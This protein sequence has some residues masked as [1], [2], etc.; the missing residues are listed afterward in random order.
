MPPRTIT[1]VMAEVIAQGHERQFGGAVVGQESHP[2]VGAASAQVGRDTI[3][4][5]DEETQARQVTPRPGAQDARH[6]GGH[7][8][9]DRRVGVPLPRVSHPRPDAERVPGGIERQRR[10][11]VA[12]QP[13]DVIGAESKQVGERAG[14]G[15]PRGE[16]AAHGPGPSAGARG[17]DDEVSRP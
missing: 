3:A 8:V 5:R 13:G 2:Q 15:Q 7:G 6:Q 11:R 16:L 4:G 12:G 14:A 1:N 10:G 9:H 17:E